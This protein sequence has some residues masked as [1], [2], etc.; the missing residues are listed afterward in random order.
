MIKSDG[1]CENKLFIFCACVCAC[2]C[3]RARECMRVRAFVMRAMRRVDM[4]CTCVCVYL[5]VFACV[6]FGPSSEFGAH[7]FCVPA[8]FLCACIRFI[9]IDVRSCR[10]FCIHT[11][12]SRQMSTYNLVVFPEIHFVHMCCFQ[13]IHAK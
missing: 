7:S 4:S 12:H 2:I 8:D 13:R 3:I 5:R 6:Y 1:R 9:D 10:V 11:Q